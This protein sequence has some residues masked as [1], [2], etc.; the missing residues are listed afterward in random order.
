VFARAVARALTDMNPHSNL[1]H[2][3]REMIKLANVY[4]NHFPKHEKYGLS[5]QIRCCLYD[6]YGYIVEG[7]KRYHKKTTL[8]NLDIEH[9]KLRMYFNLAFELGYFEYRR[10]EKCEPQK[11][12]VRRYTAISAKINEVGAM[13]G[14]WIASQKG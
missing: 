3:S 8:T 6:I 2:K 5:Q 7:E 11:E 4:L 9:E 1:I 10:S 13:I 12:A 14:G